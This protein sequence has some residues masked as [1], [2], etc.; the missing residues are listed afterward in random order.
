MMTTRPQRNNAGNR[1][2]KLLEEEEEDDF[3]KTTYGGFQEEEEDLDYIEQEDVV[4]SDFSIDE[5]DEPVSDVDEEKDKKKRGRLIT[6][7]YKN[8]LKKPKVIPNS[9]GIIKKTPKPKS[10]KIQ[11]T[12]LAGEKKGIRKSTQLKSQET[13]RRRT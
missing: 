1:M 5:N 7:A 13:E 3:Y 8:H 6:K 9:S 4:D 2:S 10:E 12:I 11:R